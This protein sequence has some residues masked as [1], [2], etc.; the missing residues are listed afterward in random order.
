LKLMVPVTIR[1][2]R[3]YSEPPTYRFSTS[4]QV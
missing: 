2:A 4:L 1:P 3:D